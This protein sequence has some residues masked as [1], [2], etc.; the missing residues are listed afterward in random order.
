MTPPILSGRRTHRLDPHP[1][2]PVLNKVVATCLALLLTIP[3]SS[4][5]A[6]PAIAEPLGYPWQDNG[7]TATG[8]YLADSYTGLEADH[9]FESVTQERLL[10]LLSSPGNFYLIIGGPARA[11]SQ[12]ALPLINE[13]AKADGIEK[14][15]HFDPLI[16]GYQADIT[17][18]QTPYKVS[19]T[20]SINQLWTRITELLPTDGPLANYDSRDTLL[21]LYN[22]NEAQ[23]GTPGTIRASYTLTDAATAGLD[24]NGYKA[25]IARVFR[26][27]SGTAS[28]AEPVIPASVRTDLQFFNRIYNASATRIE[29]TVA[30]ANRIGEPVTLFDGLTEAS[31]KLHQ[32]N[33]AELLNL[34]NTPGEHIIFY[35]A[36]WCHNTQ[37]IIGTVA[38]QAARTPGVDTVYVYDTTL[39]NQ[40]RFGTGAAIDTATATSSTFNSRNAGSVNFN[41]GYLYAEA[42]RPLGNFITEN[43]SYQNNSIAYYPNGDLNS[44]L[45][46]VNPWA[47]GDAASKKAIRLQLPFLVAYDNSKDEPVVRQWLH[48]QA[49]PAADGRDLYLE[50]MLELSWVRATSLAGADTSVYRNG[51]ASDTG[52]TKTAI[53]A[54]AIS[55][56]EALFTSAPSN[57][58]EGDGATNDEGDDEGNDEDNNGNNDGNND[59]DDAANDADNDE[60]N[61]NKKDDT[62]KPRDT[63][64]QNVPHNTVTYRPFGA[65]GTYTS[66]TGNTETGEEDTTPKTERPAISPVAIDEPVTPQV[67]PAKPQTSTDEAPAD[68]AGDGTF[69]VQ[70]LVAVV[71]VLLTVFGA[72][73]LKLGLIRLPGVGAAGRRQ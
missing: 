37:A 30:S 66:G 9:V 6:R 33:F 67:A 51:A 65:A 24:A 8:N 61:D 43:N 16:D 10:D 34:Y 47:E 13:Q 55:G 22:R 23:P 32:I 35:G 25:G 28:L 48:K 54:E 58:D 14:I 18:P 20:A 71:V 42:V 68:A 11:S 45:T 40:L 38:A 69:P 36:S 31:F 72:V 2:Q 4:F 26:G 21:L 62:V 56:V 60:G 15:Y 17:D 46:T 5:L 1:V 73:A 49:N 12:A 70:V 64:E 19:G 41:V 50:Y 52:Q 7:G 3:V 63:A 29:G 27:L 44:A 53:A 57:N 39:G 59:G